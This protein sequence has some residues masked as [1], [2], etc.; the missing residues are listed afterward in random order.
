MKKWIAALISLLVIIVIAI[1]LMIPSPIRISNIVP[2]K[3]SSD[4]AYR[5]LIVQDNWDKIAKG[6]IKITQRLIN[7]IRLNVLENKLTTPVTLFLIPITTDSVVIN[8]ESSMPVVKRPIAKLQQYSQAKS[9]RKKMDNVFDSLKLFLQKNENIYGLTINEASTKDTFLIAT[10][11]NSTTY[12]ANKEIYEQIGK[13]TS[14][15]N[16]MNLKQTGFP[17]LNVTQTDSGSLKC[18][19]AIPIDK[20]TVDKGAVFFVRMVPGRFLTTQVTGGHST[21]EHAHKMMQ[22]YFS[23]YKRTAMAIPFEYLVTDRLHE[24][25]TSKWVTK[26]Y[27]PVY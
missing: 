20:I 27:C 25:D 22:M 6:D 9:L 14:Y 1:Y 3:T 26:I 24:A 16:Q 19:V 12:P 13:L 5:G 17:M 11:F 8:W 10:K 23:D 4:A 15:A 7:T 2:V 18:T 21:I